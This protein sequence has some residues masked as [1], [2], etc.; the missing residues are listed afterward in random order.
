MRYLHERLHTLREGIAGDSIRP[1]TWLLKELSQILPIARVDDEVIVPDLVR[2]YDGVT[3]MKNT[4]WAKRVELD[5][6]AC[7]ILNSQ[8]ERYRGMV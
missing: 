6:I 7:N 4:D 3:L 5:Q 1:K 2:L 8:E